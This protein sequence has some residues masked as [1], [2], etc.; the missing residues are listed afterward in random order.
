MANL[1]DLDNAVV[2]ALL[3]DSALMAICTD[4]VWFGDATLGATRFVSVD[5]MEHTPTY[6]FGG[7]AWDS[8]TYQVKATIESVSGA[9]IKTA[10]DRIDALLHDATLTATGY[11]VQTT[12]L[13]QA[14]RYYETDPANTARRWWHG[15]GRYEVFAIPIPATTKGDHG[16]TNRLKGAMV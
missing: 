4:G 3:N 2:A 10:A 13:R 16:A 12:L 8:V 6:D 11:L 1:F 15:G 7:T 14:I 9:D 5:R